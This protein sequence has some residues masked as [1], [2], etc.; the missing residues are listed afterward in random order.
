MY[1]TNTQNYKF[2]SDPFIFA[3]SG[4]R[5][6]QGSGAFTQETNMHN[7]DDMNIL[8]LDLG[9]EVWRDILGY[10]GQYKVSSFGQIMSIKYTDRKNIL[11]PRCNKRGYVVVT[12]AK[13]GD[14]GK[15]FLV[16]R[17]VWKT[18]NGPLSWKHITHVD[19]DKT[20]NNLDN[21][22]LTRK[23]TTKTQIRVPK[24]ILPT[25]IEGLYYGR[26]QYGQD[27]PIVS[28][29]AQETKSDAWQDAKDMLRELEH[30]EQNEIS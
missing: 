16:H 25:K 24:M 11:N 13:D 28:D 1:L 30:G 22:A 10:K 12:L 21:L 27:R 2:T 8:G 23:Y 20:N 17:I 18:F 3:L 14:G 26:V 15:T 6:G 9:L 7:D 19:G 4:Q 29:K 5:V